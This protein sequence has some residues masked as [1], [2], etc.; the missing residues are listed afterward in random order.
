MPQMQTVSKNNTVIYKGHDN[1][2]VVKLHQTEV[3]RFNDKKIIL[4]SGGWQTVTTKTRMNQASNQFGLGYYVYQKD[5][6]W[7]VDY[8]GCTDAEFYDGFEIER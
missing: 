3:V 2:I 6:E 4:N 8:N 5:H 1:M 7:F